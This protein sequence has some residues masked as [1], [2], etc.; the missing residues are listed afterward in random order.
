M[1]EE[2]A[3]HDFLDAGIDLRSPVER[4]A[5]TI[6]LDD[7]F[8]N[9]RLGKTYDLNQLDL[10]AVLD[11]EKLAARERHLTVKGPAGAGKSTC[12]NGCFEGS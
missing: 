12:C 11:P 7:I 8:L 4:P 6:R 3:N 1:A 5:T 9:L 10:G 2:F